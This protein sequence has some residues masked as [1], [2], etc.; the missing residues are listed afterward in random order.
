[1]AFNSPDHSP[2]DSICSVMQ[3]QVY[4]MLFRNINELKKRLVEVWSRTSTNRKCI[5]LPSYTNGWYFEYLLS[6]VAQLDNWINRQPNVPNVCYLNQMILHWIKMSVLFSSCSA[7]TEVWWGRNINGHLMASC[8]WS[9]H[10]KKK[11]WC[12][13]L[14]LT[15]YNWLIEPA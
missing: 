4:E 9:I 3:Q 14:C 1:V 5:S 6:T 11:L 7:E 8:V 2:F 13:F 15:V 10:T 12:V